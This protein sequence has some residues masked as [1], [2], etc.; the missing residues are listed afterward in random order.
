MNDAF[1]TKFS[2]AGNTLDYSTYLGGSDEDAGASIA[3]D[4]SGAAYVTGTTASRNFPTQN[5]FQGAN[6]GFD[7]AFV[8]KINPTAPPCVPNITLTITQINACTFQLSGTVTCSGAPV[9]GAS[10]SFTSSL[11]GTGSVSIAPNPATTD[12]AGNYTSTMTADPGTS[13][14]VTVTTST[15]VNGTPISASQST[16]VNCPCV[17][18]INLLITSVNAC[19]FQISG[20]VTCSGAPIAGTSVSFTTSLTGTGSVSID[21]N[22]ATTDASGNYTSTVTAAPGTSST[23]TVTASTT[24]NETPISA[25]QSSSINCPSAP[26]VITCPADIKVFND[27]GRNGAIVHFPAPDISPG[28]TASCFPPSGSFFRKGNTTVTCKATDVEGNTA[29]CSFNVRV[30]IDPCR[31]FIGGCCD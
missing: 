26:P 25:S 8:T 24:V 30:V 27:P 4:S 1:V 9:A 29:T 10:V 13:G 31:F 14:T 6:A 2:P 17:P 15:T 11:A 18:N 19:T 3:V 21:P 7:D 22:P 20:T 28:A 12:A 16:S 5:P 23:V